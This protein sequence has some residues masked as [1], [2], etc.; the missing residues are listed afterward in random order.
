ML[1][2]CIEIDG[3]FLFFILSRDG[4]S[5]EPPTETLSNFGENSSWIHRFQR[6]RVFDL[7]ICLFV[8]FIRSKNQSLLLPL[9]DF[10]QVVSPLVTVLIY[11][12][13]IRGPFYLL[14]SLCQKQWWSF[15]HMTFY[16]TL[17]ENRLWKT[18]Q[19]ERLAPRQQCLTWD[20]TGLCLYYKCIWDP[21][22]NSKPKAS[23]DFEHLSVA[24][25]S[26]KIKCK[27]LHFKS[28]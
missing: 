8:Y 10:K 17:N 5:S 3:Q 16:F 13:E 28:L 6:Q 18:P 11:L 7:F 26:T 22:Q 9:T 14:K 20:V 23:E 2:G 19:G 12:G 24:Y 15:L 21:R 25:L 27:V 1:R 4:S